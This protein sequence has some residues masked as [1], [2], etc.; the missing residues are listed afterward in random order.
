MNATKK[1]TLI[2]GIITSPVLAP[3][4]HAA[5]TLLDEDFVR[6]TAA[7]NVA[8]EQT[9]D[10]SMGS[11]TLF[12]GNNITHNN[13][14]SS[15]GS[16]VISNNSTGNS[17]AALVFFDASTLGAGTFQANLDFLASNI[18]SDDPTQP[19]AFAQ[20]F[21]ITG[22]TGVAGDEVRFDLNA[23][24]SDFNSG[25]IPASINGSG[26]VTAGIEAFGG[27]SITQVGNNVTIPGAAGSISGSF[28]LTGDQANDAG[29]F[30]AV[31]LVRAGDL[32]D[33]GNFTVSNVSIETIPEPSSTLL[34]GLGG[35]GLLA[36]RRR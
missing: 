8:G 7:S 29:D 28:T 23:G 26:I 36:R 24:P 19:G 22:L 9:F 16:L 14:V 13:D 30:I 17:R 32:I 12:L 20:V 6:T 33:S 10:G 21:S 15:G 27:A 34:F 1:I 35:L 11:P 2:A 4:L 25:F 5:T 31:A 18:I 3:S